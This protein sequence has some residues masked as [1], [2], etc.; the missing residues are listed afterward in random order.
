MEAKY[1]ALTDCTKHAQWTLSLL[2]QLDFEVN[3]PLSIYCDSTGAQ[4]IAVNSVFHK[5]TKHIDIRYHYICEVINDGIVD[6]QDVGVDDNTADL[7]T[8]LMTCNQHEFL[9]KK[10]GLIDS[11]IEGKCSKSQ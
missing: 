8:K 11:Q 3:L 7:L 10:T 5:R 1:M 6:I 2:Q 4:A 9:S